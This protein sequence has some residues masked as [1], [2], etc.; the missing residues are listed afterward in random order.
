MT[1]KYSV[2]VALFQGVAAGAVGAEDLL[3]KI[4]FVLLKR[5]NDK[6]ALGMIGGAWSPE[7]DGDGSSASPI[8]DGNESKESD[9]QLC[10]ALSATAVRVVR[11]QLGADLS[12][13]VW[14]ELLRIE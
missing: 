2:R 13:C 14:T 4:K 11:E 7:L 12:N 5:P 9:E 3:S 8:G 6:G 10:K 1:N